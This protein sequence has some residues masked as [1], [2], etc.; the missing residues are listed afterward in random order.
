M[1]QSLYPFRI[2][3]MTLDDVP[4]AVAIEQAAY[5]SDFS[6]RDFEYEL[7]QMGRSEIPGAKIGELVMD[8]LLRVDQ[9][10]YVRFA[11]VYRSF[12]D[13]GSLKKVVDDLVAGPGNGSQLPLL[14]GDEIS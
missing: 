9:I 10:A 7:Q 5:P 4:G 14:S 2:D 11:S 13:I 12:A 3:N 8:R 1:S 6:R